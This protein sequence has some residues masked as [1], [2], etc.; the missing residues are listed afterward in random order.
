VIV[1]GFEVKA[2]AGRRNSS[3]RLVLLKIK[4]DFFRLPVVPTWHHLLIEIV[5]SAFT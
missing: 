5:S 3:S 1:F 2:Q 4:A